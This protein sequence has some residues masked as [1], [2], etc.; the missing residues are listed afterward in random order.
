MNY[1]QALSWGKKELNINNIPSYDLDALILLEDCTG[2]DRSNLL[3]KPDTTIE[4]HVVRK[5]KKQIRLRSQHIPVAYLRHKTE[6]YGHTFYI[7]QR[8]LEPRPESEA[9]IDELATIIPNMPDKTTL[10][11]VGTGSGALSITAKLMHPELLVY[12]TDIS[13]GAINVTRINAQNL[14]TAINPLICDLIS[15][16]PHQT[17]NNPTVIIANLPYIPDFWQINEAAQNEPKIAIYGGNDGLRLYARLF[18]QLKT[19]SNLPEFILCESL[20]PQHKQLAEIASSL[21]Y[22][23]LTTN[24][25]VQIFT[26]AQ[27]LK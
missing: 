18:N 13:Q 8:V 1:N 5:F 2:V 24:N 14:K 4:T 7:D 6:F 19:V 12:A 16:I 20:P 21:N 9:I 22:Q 27:R 11:D 3:S 10:I 17:W 23:L 15:L 26:K 25:F